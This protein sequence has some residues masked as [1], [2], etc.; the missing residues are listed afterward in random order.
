[1]LLFCVQG[2]AGD[3]SS[4]GDLVNE[5]EFTLLSGARSHRHLFLFKGAMLEC[6]LRSDG[7]LSVK[8]M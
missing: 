4:Y 5:A 1:M 3:L 6:K 8:S 2:L 7:A